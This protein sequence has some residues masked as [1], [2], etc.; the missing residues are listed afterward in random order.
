MAYDIVGPWSVGPAPQPNVP[1]NFGGIACR[2]RCRSIGLLITAGAVQTLAG[3]G[4]W[5]QDFLN[6]FNPNY[7]GG[8]Y[9]PPQRTAV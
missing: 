7:G 3:L 2:S 4:G 9:Y 8:G 1:P 6:A 5:W